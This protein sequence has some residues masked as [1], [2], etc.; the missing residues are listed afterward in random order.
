MLRV[1]NLP[2]VLKG[3]LQDGIEGCVIMT[4]EGSPLGSEFKSS[5]LSDT[6]L[7]AISS[8]LWS[9]YASVSPGDGLSL[10][11]IKLEKGTLGIGRVGSD[12]LVAAYG[13]DVNPGMLRLKLDALSA[14]FS[15]VFEQLK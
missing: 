13:R 3:A 11:I 5:D 8:T 2:E 15:A 1:S 10:Q 14:Y 6:V 4:A 12:Y 7:A 9:N